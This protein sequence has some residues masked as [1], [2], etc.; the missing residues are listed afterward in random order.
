MTSTDIAREGAV[1]GSIDAKCVTKSYNGRIALDSISFRVEPGQFYAVVGPSGCGKTTLLKIVH[2]LVRASSGEVHVN[3]LPVAEPCRS[4]AVVFQGD[5]LM[6]WRSVLDNIGFGLEMGG[7]KREQARAKARRYLE[8]VELEDVAHYQP[9]QLSGGMRQ[10][11]NL[12][13]ALAVEPEVLLMDEPFAALDAQTREVMQEELLRIWH[14]RSQTVM[15]VTHQID[16]AVL[17]A[18]RIL[19][20]G[21][22][23]GRVIRVVDVDLPRPRDLHMKR[24]AAFGELVEQVWSLI[25]GEAQKESRRVQS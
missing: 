9:H 15:F 19:V 22:R 24:S 10:R 5:S 3:G 13:R 6:P 12:A 4:R 23:P 17:L 18:D 14:Q 2:G 7:L 8:L 1:T 20:L 25:S 11:V 16:E 21:S